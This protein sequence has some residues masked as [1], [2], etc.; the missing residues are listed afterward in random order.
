MKGMI[1][2]VYDF[3]PNPD[4]MQNRLTDLMNRPRH[5]TSEFIV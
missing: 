3:Q 4:Y 5:N 2:K 1:T